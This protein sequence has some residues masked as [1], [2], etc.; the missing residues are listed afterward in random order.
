MIP[1][2]VVSVRRE[3]CPECADSAGNPCAS[4]SHGKWGPYIQCD[5]PALPSL[6]VRARN[7]AVQSAKE[8]A[9]IASGVPAVTEE[10]AGRRLAICKSNVCGFWRA[11]DETCSQCGCPMV[12]KSPWRSARCPAGK[13]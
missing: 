13:W 1:F 12:K 2:A 7:L 10:E 4:C 8:A 11:S 5:E 9:A 3:L 6:P